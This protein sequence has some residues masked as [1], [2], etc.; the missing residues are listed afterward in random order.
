MFASIFG[1]K[2]G[3]GLIK[4]IISHQLKKDILAYSIIYR[5]E[6][7][8]KI[9]FLIDNEEIPYPEGAAIA[10]T[11]GS[12]IVEKLGDKGTVNVAVISYDETKDPVE[13]FC[14]AGYTDKD[15]NK[16]RENYPL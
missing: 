11:I 5:N 10:N 7:G 6:D 9:S 3:L 4:K 14:N 2:H 15:G 13:C 16:Q 12:M 1:P 8:G